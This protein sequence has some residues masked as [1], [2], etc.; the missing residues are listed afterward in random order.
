MMSIT[1][2]LDDDAAERLRREADASGR[3]V[4]EL[5]GERLG[6]LLREGEAD[7]VRPRAVP[8]PRNHDRIL[9]LADASLA[10]GGA[11]RG[12]DEVF[13]RLERR[14]RDEAQAAAKPASNPDA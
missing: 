11:D 14:V 12:V 6:R 7:G 3:D 9:A 5:A 2:R 8:F 1:I 10:S 4:A 13:D